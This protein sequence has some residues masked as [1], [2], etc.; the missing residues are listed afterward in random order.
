ML[1]ILPRT[2]LNVNKSHNDVRQSDEFFMCAQSS[3]AP[4][5]PTRPKR[6]INPPKRFEDFVVASVHI[7][8]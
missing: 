5:V 7:S 3:D 8:E 1:R 6:Q 4:K 2:H